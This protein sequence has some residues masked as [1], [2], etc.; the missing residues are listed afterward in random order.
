[1]STGD[2]RYLG[3]VFINQENYERQK[4][5]FRD[6]IDSYQYKYGGVFDAATLQGTV[7]SDYA[8]KEQGE[9]A[10]NAILSPLRIGKK[11]IVNIEDAQYIYT[12]A[13][14]LDRDDD[15]LEAID[16][17]MNLDDDNVTDALIAIY[18]EVSSIQT[19]LQNNIDQKFDTEDYLDFYEN[20]YSEFKNNVSEVFEEFTDEYG[21]VVQKLNAQLVNGLRFILITQA[22]YDQLT[23]T[24]KNYWRNIYIIKDPSEIPPEY[25]DPM[26]WELTD[27]YTFAINDG[28]LQVTNGLS[29]TWKTICTLDELISGSNFDEI[30]SDFLRLNSFTIAPENIV[31]SITEISNDTIE[32]DWEDYPFLSSAL[33]DDFVKTITIN[34]SSSNITETINPTTNFKTVDLGI[35]NIIQSSDTVTSLQQDLTSAQ[36]DINS[37]KN[38]IKQIDIEELSDTVNNINSRISNTISQDILTNQNNIQS[39]ENRIQELEK[40]VNA[41]NSRTY[42]ITSNINNWKT[43][44]LGGYIAPADNWNS[45]ITKASAGNAGLL[46]AAS[47]YYISNVQYNETLG[48]ARIYLSFYHWHRA[49]KSHI[50][51]WVR[52]AVYYKKGGKY[53]YKTWYDFNEQVLN[54][55]VGKQIK[56]IS[57]NVVIPDASKS[58]A[59]SVSNHK[60]YANIVFPNRVSPYKCFINIEPQTGK[61]YVYVNHESDKVIHF[62]GSYLYPLSAPGQEVLDLDIT[63][64]EEVE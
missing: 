20:D 15:R 17:Y 58:T 44:Y 61:I 40:T 14:L 46:S 35:E 1:M 26:M 63:D 10:D 50:R 18:N 38:N 55:R 2:K 27:G 49:N 59:T 4:Q 7:P 47:K 24:E 45:W 60:P 56:G 64:N 25:V 22:K 3:D 28:A 52:P 30:I 8:T 32:S 23:D 34:N 39:H 9:K 29:D 11:E 41:I 21:N 37:I 62:Y 53:Y 6:I 36:T 57:G 51:Q 31:N 54:N 33:R 13:V 5:F 19:E 43:S 48:I 42:N 12:D 16:W